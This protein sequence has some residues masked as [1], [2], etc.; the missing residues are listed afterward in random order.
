MPKGARCPLERWAESPV[1]LLGDSH[2]LV[3]SRGPADTLHSV[4]GGLA[5]LLALELGF[6][7]D[8]IGV[9]GSGST[10]ARAPLVQISVPP[11]E[12]QGLPERQTRGYL[13]LLGAGTDG[14]FRRL[15]PIALK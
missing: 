3:F 1:I 6:P 14:E 2:T 11:P 10:S 5:D 13:V 4:G 15:V 7:V 12:R 8:L 9:R